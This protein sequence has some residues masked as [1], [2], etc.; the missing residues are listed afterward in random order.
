VQEDGELE[1]SLG[2]TVVLGQS[3][4]RVRPVS[5]RNRKRVI[6]YYCYKNTLPRKKTRNH[7]ETLVT[8]RSKRTLFSSVIFYRWVIF[9]KIVG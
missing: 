9:K 6:L 3:G 2:N 1:A 7:A 5:K 8:A 4:W